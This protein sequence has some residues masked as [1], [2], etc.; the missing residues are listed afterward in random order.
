MQVKSNWYRMGA[1]VLTVKRNN[2]KKI[3]CQK[4]PQGLFFEK[5]VH[6]FQLQIHRGNTQQVAFA[7]IIFTKQ[8]Y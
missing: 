6:R 7:P 1:I 5:I 8:S 3:H 2:C 4:Q